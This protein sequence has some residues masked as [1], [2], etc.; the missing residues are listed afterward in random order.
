MTAAMV[1]ECTL[2]VDDEESATSGAKVMSIT[3]GP[4]TVALTISDGAAMGR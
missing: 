4:A 2:V 3:T 1:D